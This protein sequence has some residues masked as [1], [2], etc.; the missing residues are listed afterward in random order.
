MP[1]KYQH[2]DLAYLEDIS[3]GDIE[4]KKQLIALFLEQMEDVKSGFTSALACNDTDEMRKIAHLAKSS[5]K[6]MGISDL[7]AKMQE[8]EQSLKTNAEKTDCR[9]YTQYFFDHI[10]GAIEEINIEMA[11]W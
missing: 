7:S 5:T 4:T 10:G 1:S 8:F 9:Y 2:I 6:I 11:A 3:S